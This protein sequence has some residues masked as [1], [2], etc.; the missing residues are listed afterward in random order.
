M[1]HNHFQ[2][3]AAAVLGAGLIAQPA[4]AQQRHPSR[5]SEN[6]ADGQRSA[7][8]QAAP[9]AQMP[10]SRPAPAAPPR[11]VASSVA[12][13]PPV[14]VAP[15]SAVPR[16]S[17]AP[18]TNQSVVGPRVYAVPRYET[19]VV[20]RYVP[21]A[22][23]VP[24]YTYRPFAR[25]FYAFRPHLSLGFSLWVGYPV[26]YPVYVNAYPYPYPSYSY[27]AYTTGV[28]G[29]S[30]VGGL[31]FDITPADAGVYVDGEYVGTVADFSPTGAANALHFADRERREVIIEHELFC[32]F[33]EQAVH[34]L[35]IF[36]CA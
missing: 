30:T 13:R 1:P 28:V 27:P 32:V 4:L 18:R 36:R 3:I 11:A 14:V 22:V 35:F 5:S 34:S 12:P 24:S 8:A 7:G 23:V 6:H 10:E 21:R 31:S 25:P 20:P 26:A 29:P 9:R 33:F 19:R 15:Q 16:E 17:A 2:F